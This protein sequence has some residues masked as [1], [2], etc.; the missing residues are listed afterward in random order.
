MLWGMQESVG[1]I[2]P[3]RKC[4]CTA[5]LHGQGFLQPRLMYLPG[6]KLTWHKVACCVC[7]QVLG[8]APNRLDIFLGDAGAKL[9]Q[10]ID[11]QTV[12]CNTTTTGERCKCL[13]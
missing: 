13:S 3:G 9:Q 7:N 2:Q 6:H 10:Q 1:A 8:K 11:K 12:A 5:T 4:V